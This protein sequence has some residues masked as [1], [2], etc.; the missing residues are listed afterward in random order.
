MQCTELTTVLVTAFESILELKSDAITCQLIRAI[1][2]IW[3]VAP[4]TI[5]PYNH[6]ILKL[7]L[8]NTHK[9]GNSQSTIT[10]PCSV[11]DTSNSSTKSTAAVLSAIP[12]LLMLQFMETATAVLCI[13]NAECWDATCMPVL[14]QL[15]T[16]VSKPTTTSRSSKS[17]TPKVTANTVS[18]DERLH[19]WQALCVMTKPLINRCTTVSVSETSTITTSC[20]VLVQSLASAVIAA[21]RDTSMPKLRQ[22][23]ECIGALLLLHKPALFLPLFKAELSDYNLKAQA[24]SSLLIMLG[25]ALHVSQ[26]T[27]TEL[28]AVLLHDTNSVHELL[29]TLLPWLGA[30]HSFTRVVAQ[31]VSHR[32]LSD[33]SF[34]T[35]TAT[36]TSTDGSTI[37][38]D[39]SMQF[40]TQQ[41][42]FLRE[43][44]EVIDMRRK[45]QDTFESLKLFKQCSVGGLVE[46]YG[47][48]DRGE[49][50]SQH[51]SESV[52]QSL[53]TM[54]TS[55]TESTD[56]NTT[57]SN[58]SDGSNGNVTSS[59]D[60]SNSGAVNDISV[61]TLQRKIL[62][63]WSQ[64][65]LTAPDSLIADS[66]N[67][68]G[69]SNSSSA[70]SDSKRNA[71]CMS[72]QPFI[73]CASLVSNSINIGGLARTCE[74]MSVQC[75]LVNDAKIVD[76]A[77]FK[78]LSLS[79]AQVKKH[80]HAYTCVMRDIQITMT[81]NVL[82]SRWRARLP[83]ETVA[84]RF[85]LLLTLRCTPSCCVHYD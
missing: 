41:A 79:A 6:H 76:K 73:L 30:A 9:T 21:N 42:R 77:D 3:A 49:I 56:D 15:L 44:N 23:Q 54:I 29:S 80:L 16:L 40:W 68:N 53:L 47:I 57:N 50:Q 25:Y 33:S 46:L 52:K 64:L 82:F 58:T 19:A 38:N 65:E 83:F 74:I 70:S 85:K 7:L 75:M 81:L 4:H 48:D 39:Q 1:T 72:R 11:D 66:Y 59:N 24:A 18:N 62:T 32:L 26:E 34:L 37:N 28:T 84:C 35:A 27:H 67:I 10:F 2:A 43:N 13:Q 20:E 17:A 61:S 5:I 78:S 45:Q 8:S 71:E 60:S 63:P 36:T 69:S 12:R 51:I 22:S 31:L 14:Q 55:T